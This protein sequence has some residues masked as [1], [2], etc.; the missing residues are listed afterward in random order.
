LVVSEAIG[1]RQRRQHV[2]LA[3]ARRDNVS[4]HRAGV[5]VEPPGLHPCATHYLE[6]LAERDLGLGKPG[7]DLVPGLVA[8]GEGIRE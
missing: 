7:G 1:E 6:P 2:R 3:R 5:D 8:S 4:C